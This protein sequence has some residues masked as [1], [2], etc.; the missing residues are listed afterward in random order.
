MGEL[1]GPAFDPAALAGSG[2]RYLS[3]A[4]GLDV[5]EKALAQLEALRGAFAGVA[6]QYWP[7]LEA[8]IMGARGQVQQSAQSYTGLGQTLHTLGDGVTTIDVDSGQGITST[9]QNTVADTR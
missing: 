5:D 9:G 3:H 2:S 1:Q 8:A 4:D 6:R 7:A